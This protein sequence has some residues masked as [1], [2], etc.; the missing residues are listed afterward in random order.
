MDYTS[1]PQL[2]P[3]TNWRIS[4]HTSHCKNNFQLRVSLTDEQFGWNMPGWTSPSTQE[5]PAK[6]TLV[7]KFAFPGS[8]HLVTC[9]PPLKTTP[10]HMTVPHLAEGYVVGR[11][12]LWTSPWESLI[13][14]QQIFCTAAHQQRLTWMN[15]GTYRLCH[16]AWDH[17]HR[18]WGKR[19]YLLSD[20]SVPHLE[21]GVQN[22]LSVLSSSLVTGF[23]LPITIKTD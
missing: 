6:T 11:I 17:S 7:T 13:W 5:I 18:F 10:K 15:H 2:A 19:R 4:V 22:Q 14:P 1:S 12:Y 16:P 23:W 3:H 9:F 21:P 8:C 20:V